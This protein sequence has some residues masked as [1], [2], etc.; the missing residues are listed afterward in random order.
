LKGGVFHIFFSFF[1]TNLILQFTCYIELNIHQ[2]FFR[3]RMHTYFDVPCPPLLFTSFPQTPLIAQISHFRCE[4]F[5][6]L[7]SLNVTSEPSFKRLY[8][9]P[10]GCGRRDEERPRRTSHY[11]TRRTGSPSPLVRT[12]SDVSNFT[13]VSDYY[14]L[15]FA[16]HVFFIIY[17]FVGHK[18]LFRGHFWTVVYLY[19]EHFKIVL[20]P[21]VMFLIIHPMVFDQLS[22]VLCINWFRTV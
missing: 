15:S 3:N 5:L 16:N 20:R 9:W 18:L 8:M 4:I 1:D 12:H 2:P 10:S 22:I 7:N 19:L 6:K 21:L 14:L 13:H 17:C 11:E